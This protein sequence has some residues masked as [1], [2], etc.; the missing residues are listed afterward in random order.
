M[1]ER[2]SIIQTNRGPRWTIRAI[3]RELEWGKRPTRKLVHD[4]ISV[5]RIQTHS[6][7]N[8]ESISEEDALA[9]V[10]HVEAAEQK[11]LPPGY[12]T[13]AKILPLVGL[14]R[15]S[16]KNQLIELRQCLKKWVE[17]EKLDVYQGGLVDV[18]TTRRRGKAAKKKVLKEATGY[19]IKQFEDLWNKEC[20]V[21]TGVAHLRIRLPLDKEMPTTT[22]H[23]KM[24]ELGFVGVRLYKA[25]EK[26]GVISRHHA[27][28]SSRGGDARVSVRLGNAPDPAALAKEIKK[29][30]PMRAREVRRRAKESRIDY[31]K[32]RVEM[33]ELDLVP[34]RPPGYRQRGY[35]VLLKARGPIRTRS[36]NERLH[37]KS[38]SSG[39][40]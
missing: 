7:L 28:G 38:T 6:K 11:G 20:S 23:A 39:R 5:D 26:A 33:H 13:W 19:N 1:S 40:R 15:T 35:W 24:A 18:I 27:E 16:S 31:A 32:L 22:L 8:T 2:P 12:A 34:Y 4:R 17:L 25:M 37:A 3:A 36:A 10:K 14:K 30:V 9:L 29:Q 21:K